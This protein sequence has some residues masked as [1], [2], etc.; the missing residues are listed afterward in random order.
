MGILKPHFL[1]LQQELLAREN[2]EPVYPWCWP[3]T[4]RTFV[5]PK[6]AFPA[7]GI[8]KLPR[9]SLDIASVC[10]TDKKYDQL[11]AFFEAFDKVKH[12]EENDLA[13]LLSNLPEDGNLRYEGAQLYKEYWSKVMTRSRF[14]QKLD[15][16]IKLNDC[17]PW[18]FARSMG[19]PYPPP[20]GDKAS[21]QSISLS[22]R[23]LP[24]ATIYKMRIRV[25][26]VVYS[27]AGSNITIGL[28]GEECCLTPGRPHIVAQKIMISFITQGWDRAAKRYRA[29][30]KRHQTLT[31]ELEA[32]WS[33]LETMPVNEEPGKK[34]RAFQALFRR[35]SRYC[36]IARALKDEAA[37]E[38]AE[39][40]EARIREIL[41]NLRTRG[42]ATLTGRAVKIRDLLKS[43]ISLEDIEEMER[44]Y[45]ET[46]KE[47]EDLPALEQ[48]VDVE[49][50]EKGGDIG[51]AEFREKTLREI[52]EF[53]GLAELDEDAPFPFLN[54]IIHDSGLRP[55]EITRFDE[56]N[57]VKD[58]HELAKN[59]MRPFRP[60]WHQY[61]GLAA[62]VKRFFEGKNALLADGVGVGKTLECFMM[63]CFLRHLRIAQAKNDGETQPKLPAIA[64]MSRR[65]PAQW[66]RRPSQGEVLPGGQFLV[67]VPNPLMKQWYD[68]AKIMLQKGAWNIVWYPS[69]AAERESFWTTLWPSYADTDHSIVLLVP[70]SVSPPF[71]AFGVLTTVQIQALR[72][73]A[74]ETFDVGQRLRKMDQEQ[75]P[76][77]S[78][79]MHGDRTANTLFGRKWALVFWDEAQWLRT[80][81]HLSRAAVA[82]RVRSSSTILCSATPLHNGE[83]DLVSL[84]LVL[85]IGDGDKLLNL[86]KE[87][88]RNLAAIKKRYGK[89]DVTEKQ[90]SAHLAVTG[91]LEP[92]KPNTREFEIESK[93]V[94]CVSKMRELFK[95]IVI[96]RSNKSV[97][98]EGKVI[99]GLPELSMFYVYVAMGKEERAKFTTI[100]DKTAQKISRE[101]STSNLET[102]AFYAEYR[103]AVGFSDLPEPGPD[104]VRPSG[105]PLWTTRDDWIKGRSVK[106]SMLTKLVLALLNAEDDEQLPRTDEQG[107]VVFPKV[108]GLP[109]E[110]ED[111]EVTL[112]SE[113]REW[114][115]VYTKRLAGDQ[116][117]EAISDWPLC[118]KGKSK[119]IIYAEYVLTLPYLVRGLELSGVQCIAAAGSKVHCNHRAWTQM[120]AISAFKDPE[121]NYRVLI[122]TSVGNAGLNLHEAR[123]MIFAD[124]VWS[125][126]TE[127]QVIGR[128]YRQPNEQLC[129]VY[130]P[131]VQETTDEFLTRTG[132]SKIYLLDVFYKERDTDRATVESQD[133]SD[134]DEVPKKVVRK[135]R[136]RKTAGDEDAKRENDGKEKPKRTRKAAAKSSA[137]KAKSAEEINSDTETTLQ[138]LQQ[139]KKRGT[140]KPE[141]VKEG[142]STVT[143]EVPSTSSNATATKKKATP[144][145]RAKARTKTID[146]SGGPSVGALQT[147]AE[148]LAGNTGQRSV[149]APVVSSNTTTSLTEPK[150]LQTLETSPHDEAVRA[151]A[152]NQPQME[153]DRPQPLL[154]PASE[155]DTGVAP[156]GRPGPREASQSMEVDVSGPIVNATDQEPLDAQARSPFSATEV[157]HEL[158]ETKRADPS[159]NG[160]RAQVDAFQM[161]SRE[162]T[163]NRSRDDEAPG[164]N[165]STGILETK[166]PAEQG[167][168]VSTVSMVNNLVAEYSDNG[169]SASEHDATEGTSDGV[170][171]SN[172]E[173][174]V[175]SAALSSLSSL[176]TSS[177][178]AND[179]KD[180][181]DYGDYG[182]N[183]DFQYSFDGPAYNDNVMNAEA[184]N[185][186]GEGQGQGEATNGGNQ[187]QELEEE[188]E[189]MGEDDEKEAMAMGEDDEEDDEDPDIR[190]NNKKR[191]RG[192]GEDDEEDDQAMGEDDEEDDEDPNIRSSNKK[193]RRAVTNAE[194]GPS[195]KPLLRRPKAKGLDPDEV[196]ALKSL[197]STAQVNRGLRRSKNRGGGRGKGR[198]GRGGGPGK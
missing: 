13:K 57:E 106:W 94:E 43:M 88:R 194:P 45:A 197:A 11:Q 79:S 23:R 157:D 78:K 171:R 73:E 36:E 129:R 109:G 193:H 24:N 150:S 90:L 174:R 48:P 51:V 38:L 16:E 120:D 137:S 93:R 66:G 34:I 28:F 152:P 135:R 172:R 52:R 80:D 131:I 144:K 187:G 167:R 108:G 103:I 72:R 59:L 44:V 15:E 39:E 58:A 140:S 30:E 113:L 18:T 76:V 29:W 192:M 83:R 37:E 102:K 84:G 188:E 117:V 123:F 99:H 10:D 190:S 158:S 35:T 133:D 101:R 126:Q 195:K 98:N 176:S 33:A 7:D 40:H 162:R 175:P 65:K 125:G 149:I 119:I 25:R 31:R 166:K 3:E 4:E 186:A 21:I 170:S 62:A 49:W 183:N 138:P 74:A 50:F 145:P 17:M 130:F 60:R 97:D 182:T 82:L 27:S 9:D 178:E 75:G 118:S 14:T 163:D 155:I 46:F 136:M 95:D 91:R 161:G 156:V 8:S 169:S 134:D 159:T 64:E 185:G 56:W 71:F 189:A 61:V 85:G 184:T 132:K 53:L 198:G 147:P 2:G 180:D 54:K 104:G 142:A 12:Q 105:P 179:R 69:E 111:P 114:E 96:R 112:E 177:G 26:D 168:L 115:D 154:D 19:L 181:V 68:Q 148:I 32:D 77:A 6:G 41:E 63:M 87:L 81:G 92:P 100:A 55:D 143:D 67:A 164:V 121:K 5:F 165:S 110:F 107:N 151:A 127:A 86:E 42:Q 139:A 47:E 1:I 22:F 128:M 196:R 141:G 89:P 20:N 70:H 124:M 122:M 191:R 160:A 116:L 173:S 146:T 153:V